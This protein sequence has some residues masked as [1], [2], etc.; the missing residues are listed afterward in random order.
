MGKLE[1]ISIEQLRES[2][3]KVDEKTETL[4]L[5]VG[6]NYKNGATQSEL[7]NWYGVSRTTIHNWLNRLERLESEPLVEVISD[8]H[9][10]GRPSKLADS[11]RTKLFSVLQDS[12]EE[13]G[14]DAPAWS[15]PLVRAYINEEF[16]VEYTL[17]HIRDLMNDAGI[18]WK[19]AR[20]DYYQGDERARKA[21]KEG[22]KKTE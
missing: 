21:F 20:P 11:E 15:P 3:D 9:R 22:F 10:S 2:L 4:R 13:L 19:T 16:D 14:I 5:V 6:I 1:N 7:A 17:R 12:P 8:E 18:V